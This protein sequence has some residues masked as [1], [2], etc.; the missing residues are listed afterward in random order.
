[1]IVFKKNK[2]LQSHIKK[3]KDKGLKVGFVPTMGALHRGHTSIIERSVAENEITVCSI[4]VNPTQFNDKKDFEKYPITIEADIQKLEAAGC[5]ILFMPSADEIYPSDFEKKHFELGY[6]ET[7]LE[8]THRPGHFQGVAMVVKR[9]LE[10]VQPE[11]L[12]LGKKDLQQCKVLQYMAITEK[13]PVAIREADTLR[14]ESGL[15]MSSRNQRL[16]E[17]DKEKATAIYKSMVFI[18]ENINTKT[19]SELQT[20]AE[21]MLA[22]A[23]FD[24]IDYVAIIDTSTLKEVI[25]VNEHNKISVAVAAFLNGVRLI[26][27]MEVVK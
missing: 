26:D 25:N 19:I 14:E 6:L 5:N 10:I 7:I 4:F 12:Y 17:T 22:E 13:L 9:L 3:L 15:A 16:S 1:M 23:G 21:S 18:K 8:G 24:N 27:N 20:Q 2:A 11:V